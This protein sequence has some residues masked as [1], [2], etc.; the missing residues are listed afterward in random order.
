MADMVTRAQINTLAR[1]LGADPAALAG[2]ERLGAHNLK[3]LCERISDALFDALAPTFARV[4]KLAP[5]V[6][7]AL[8]VTV[9]LKAI[10]AEVAGRAGGALGL[11]HPDRAA[12]ILAGL[13]PTYLADAAPHLDPRTIPVLA[14]RIPAAAL[15]PAANELLRRRDYLTASR[16]VEHA[17]EQLIREFERGIDDDEGLLHT[18]ALVS[19]TDRL[20]DI[21]R[22][23]STERQ[24]R[25]ITTAAAGSADTVAA[26]LSVLARLETELA[27]PLS[28][29]L[30]HGQDTDGID[31]ILTIATDHGALPEILD[32]TDHLSDEILTRIIQSTFM[33][34]SSAVHAL[35]QAATVDRHYRTLQRLCP[36]RHENR[37]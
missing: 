22:A 15:I 21:L 2:L 5:I 31:R 19:S 27:A 35:E 16:F 24:H 6:P 26:A 32:I 34:D 1:T 10:P 23:L 3:V 28:N 30:F 36:P 33:N 37:L 4:S 29:R 7:N 17:T 14:P 12:G 25:M 9:A 18:A 20:N 11:D 8:A 13:T